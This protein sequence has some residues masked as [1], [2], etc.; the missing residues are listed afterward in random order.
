[1]KTLDNQSIQFVSGGMGFGFIKAIDWLGRYFAVEES[2]KKLHDHI[3]P[4]KVIRPS[5]IPIDSK[6]GKYVTH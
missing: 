1:M 3:E 2:F 5:G 6:T 4:S